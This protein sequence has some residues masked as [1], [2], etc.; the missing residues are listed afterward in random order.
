MENQKYGQLL[1]PD[2]KIN[3]Q[4]FREMC[5]LL[6]IR[7]L[8][9]APKTGKTYT[10]YRELESNYEDPIMV[11][12]IFD[13]HPTQQTLRKIGWVSELN[14]NSSF[15]H[16]DYDL[17]GLQQG[18]LFII[19]SGLDDGKGR[20]FRVVKMVNEIVYPSS[21]TCEIVPEYFD[22]FESVANGK[23]ID[24]LI[25]SEKLNILG[26]ENIRPMTTEIEELESQL[27]LDGD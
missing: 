24:E 23:D 10:T 11:G 18:A 20:L 25:D 15:I 17:P 8:Y 1:T 3:R 27:T 7:V 22:D 21:I 5:K 16:V 2:I 14:E 13:E 26:T 12:C 19:P 9:R 4:Y 6:G